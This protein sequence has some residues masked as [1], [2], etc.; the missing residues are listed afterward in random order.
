MSE[1]WWSRPI[2]TSNH[3]DEV[4]GEW[5]RE[6]LCLRD[7]SWFTMWMTILAFALFVHDAPADLVLLGTTVT[8]LLTGI[9]TDEQAHSH[10]PSPL[11]RC[12][13]LDRSSYSVPLTPVRFS[14]NRSNTSRVMPS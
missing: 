7:E 14:T 6:Q 1:R 12:P 11:A 5:V 3:F 13:L 9:I 4:K 8:L 2:G 10:S